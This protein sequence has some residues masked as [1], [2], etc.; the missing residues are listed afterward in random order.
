MAIASRIGL[1]E[2]AAGLPATDGWT[3][4]GGRFLAATCGGVRVASIYV[5]N[6]RVVDSEFYLAKLE[7]LGR[8][9][10]WLDEERPGDRAGDLRRLQRRAG[11]RR[12]VGREGGPSA[13]RT[14][15]RASASPWPSCG[16]GE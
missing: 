14:C 11:G 13:R 1:E 3:D 15:R 10:G 2:I 8:L 7:W 5:P 9:R 12:R 4:D 6:G 16:H